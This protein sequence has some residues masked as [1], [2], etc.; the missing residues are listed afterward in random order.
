MFDCGYNGNYWVKYALRCL[1]NN[2]RDTWTE[3]LAFVSVSDSDA[4]RLTRSFCRE[5]DI[6]VL[7][8]RIVPADCMDESEA[9][10]RYFVFVV[11]HEVAHAICD[12]RP[13]NEISATENSAQEDEA[14]RLA[15]KWY[16]DF[17]ITIC[18]PD[19]PE[20]TKD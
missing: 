12:H 5:R 4:R 7:S 19:L 1:P 6:I 10:V 2:V 16:N 20:F 9:N 15:F 3:K 8:E 11:L 17:L 13:P 14:D 18:H